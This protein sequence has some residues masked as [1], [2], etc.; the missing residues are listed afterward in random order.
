MS[1]RVNNLRLPVE[2]PESEVAAHLARQLGVAPEDIRAWRILRKSLDARSRHDLSFVYSAV[3]DLRDQ[4][5]ESSEKIGRDS[6]VSPYAAST[7]NDPSP[8]TAE[9]DERPVIV[10][11]GPA[12]R[13]VSLPSEKQ[14]APPSPKR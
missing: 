6:N 12:I 7:F 3:V 11:S 5:A 1:L 14:P 10:G 9:L 2:Q 4:S 8:G 13:Q